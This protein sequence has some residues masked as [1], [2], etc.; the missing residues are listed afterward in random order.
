MLGDAGGFGEALAFSETLADGGWLKRCCLG[1]EGCNGSAKEELGIDSGVGWV[2]GEPSEMASGWVVGNNPVPEKLINRVIEVVT[3]AANTI[4][5]ATRSQ[6]GTGLRCDR[7]K[8]GKAAH[9]PWY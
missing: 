7:C 4:T 2:D 6:F 8:L 9:S 1:D 5:A 3:P